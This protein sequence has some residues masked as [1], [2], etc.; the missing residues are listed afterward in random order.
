MIPK[1]YKE[2]LEMR[3]RESRLMASLTLWGKLSL[4]IGFPL[5]AVM[6]GLQLLNM[7]ENLVTAIFV[8]LGLLTCW[9]PIRALFAVYR[10]QKCPECGSIMKRALAGEKNGVILI[11]D[12]CKLW[13]RL[14]FAKYKNGNKTEPPADA[15]ASR[16]L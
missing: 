11:C 8:A 10:K 5:F 9:T 4:R 15:A 3:D 16:G 1:G 14:F 2:L 7:N 12:H 6:V 13:G